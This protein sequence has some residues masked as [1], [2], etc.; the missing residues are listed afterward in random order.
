MSVTKKN[1]K[2]CR[3]LSDL[4]K[5]STL[6]MARLSDEQYVTFFPYG[7]VSA[8]PQKKSDVNNA[9]PLNDLCLFTCH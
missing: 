6:M 2:M 8:Y 4:T 9:D 5:F 1:K 7:K 3:H